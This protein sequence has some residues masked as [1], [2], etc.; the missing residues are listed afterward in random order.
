MAASKTNPDM[1]MTE[2]K[3]DAYG[4]SLHHFRTLR[5]R[6]GN[7]DSKTDKRIWERGVSFGI[8]D[9][10]GTAPRRLQAFPMI[11]SARRNTPGFLKRMH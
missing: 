10:T 4:K 6:Q 11:I 2:K 8:C 3:V 9:D 5:R 1:E 7:P